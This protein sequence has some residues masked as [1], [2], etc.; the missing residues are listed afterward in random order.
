[1][2]ILGDFNLA[3]YD[4]VDGSGFSAKEEKYPFLTCL[5]EYLLFQTVD[6]P[7]WY[8]DG[9]TS[10]I[11][12]LVLFNNPDLWTK[13]EFLAAFG[14]SDH[15][16]ILT[17]LC[18]ATT[19]SL[20]KQHKVIDYKRISERLV[21]FDW[22]II[23]TSDIKE[24]WQK[25]KAVLLVLEKPHTRTFLRKQAKTLPF[26]TCLTSKLLNRKNQTWKHF[27]EKKTA[28]NYQKYQKAWNEATNSIKQLKKS[29]E[30]RLAEHI[31]NSPKLFWHYASVKYQNKHSVPDRTD[32]DPA[33]KAKILNNQ[34]ASAFTPETASQFLTPPSYTF[35][36]PMPSIELTEESVLKQLALLDVNKYAGPEGLHPIFCMNAEQK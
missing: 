18:L 27:K 32:S 5:S 31:K 17:E 10:N 35:T 20:P 36:Q 23:V 7:I 30:E 22:D 29:H 33:I 28:A 15:A 34:F 2:V 4:W 24:S 13:N 3:N 14:N 16:A 26:M 8:R 19:E 21:D 6:Q 1:M 11:M 9:E 25:F 12:D